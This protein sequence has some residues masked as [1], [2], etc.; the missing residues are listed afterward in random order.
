[1]PQ[2]LLKLL[3]HLLCEETEPNI[4]ERTFPL[5]SSLMTNDDDDDGGGMWNLLN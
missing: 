4:N 2:K 5:I 3:L 1:M